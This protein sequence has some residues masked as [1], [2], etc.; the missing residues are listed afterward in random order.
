MWNKQ[1]PLLTVAQALVQGGQYLAQ[2]SGP[3][4]LS[5]EVQPPEAL[6]FEP[7]LEAEV[8]L[9]HA[10]G[11]DKTRLYREP[12]QLLSEEQQKQYYRYLERRCQG[13][14][15]AYL[16]GRREFMSLD[17]IVNSQVLV[18]R[19]ETELLVEIILNDLRPFSGPAHLVD[20]G[21]GSGAIAVSLAY[22]LPTAMIWAIDLS[23]AAINVA[24]QNAQNHGVSGRLSFLEGDLLTNLPETLG[25]ELDWVAANLPYIPS[26]EIPLLPG[27][28]ARYEPSL[29]LDGGQDGLELYRRLIPQAWQRLKPGGKLIMEMGCNQG[30]H[31]VG[32]LAAGDW[33]AVEIIQ[34][35]A[36]LDRFV[37]ARKPT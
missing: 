3:E 15:V 16:T 25:S 26:A 32:L 14:P 28:V 34:D 2:I 24:R 31:L 1:K 36:G 13:E 6:S 29:A 12:D 4:A 27:T 30:Q 17:F 20:V 11:V 8:L 19:P 5:P 9:R 7:R 18:P 37:L 23:S 33:Q 35:Y 22:Y 21:T 10:L